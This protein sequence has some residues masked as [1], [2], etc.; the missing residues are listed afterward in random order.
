M[1]AAVFM[2]PTILNAK[3]ERKAPMQELANMFRTARE[4]LGEYPTSSGSAPNCVQLGLLA[5]S[6]MLV[7]PRFSK[8]DLHNASE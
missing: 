6:A 7:H 8:L 4:M 5:L 3:D 2:M 1:G